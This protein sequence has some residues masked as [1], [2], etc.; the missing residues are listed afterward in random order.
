MHPIATL[1]SYLRFNTTQLLHLRRTAVSASISAQHDVPF[2]S[3]IT[4]PQR[5]LSTSRRAEGTIRVQSKDC[6]LRAPIPPTFQRYATPVRD[7]VPPIPGFLLTKTSVTV[8]D[9]IRER[10]L[11]AHQV[12]ELRACP[13]VRQ[14]LDVVEPVE[15]EPKKLVLEWM[16]ATLWQI[17]PHGKLAN[18]KLPQIVAKSILEALVV[19][20]RLHAV[21]TGKYPKS[22]SLV[23][24]VLIMEDVNPNNIFLTFGDQTTPIVKLGHLDNGRP[25]HSISVHASC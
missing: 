10:E 1:L 4:R 20:Q 8:K 3:H 22:A 24:S 25:L 2:T 13:Y 23:S 16:E 17:R 14:L 11:R 19:F 9:L 6:I 21:H 7:T 18:P 15:D 12:P 5:L